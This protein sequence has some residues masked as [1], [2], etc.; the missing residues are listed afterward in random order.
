MSRMWAMK[1]RN[2]HIHT[3]VARCTIEMFRFISI[4]RNS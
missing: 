1:D 2:G 4:L 3:T